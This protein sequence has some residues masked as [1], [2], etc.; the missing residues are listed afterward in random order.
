MCVADCITRTLV[1]SLDSDSL[2]NWSQN[3][4]FSRQ[5]QREGKKYGEKKRSGNSK[6][7][8]GMQNLTELRRFPSDIVFA[9]RQSSTSKRINE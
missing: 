3:L 2:S 1:I 6:K 4:I 5:K 8:F 9:F 7:E